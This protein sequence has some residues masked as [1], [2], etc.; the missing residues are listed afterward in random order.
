M[1][2]IDRPSRRPRDTSPWERRLVLA[3]ARKE[4]AAQNR[5]LMLYEPMIRRVTRGL[6]LPGGDRQDL[7]QAGRLGILQAACAWDVT[8]G[9][10]FS[11]FARLCASR[12][13]GMA[14]ASARAHTHQVL[15][16]A[17]TLESWLPRECVRFPK[18]FS[19]ARFM[20]AWEL[21]TDTCPDRDPQ[22]KALASERLSEILARTHRLTPL[23]RHALALSANDRP[24]EEIAA[25]LGVRPRGVNN[26][27]QRAR[28]KLTGP[29][30]A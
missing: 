18:R 17:C 13:I 27:L 7:A 30:A 15:T 28:R 12:E 26:A 19:D 1:R 25:V 16:S 20:P 24:H 14:L 5:L 22:A 21:L 11:A 23:E 8:R 4:A 10:P 2:Q 6:F 29:V 9:V 3:A